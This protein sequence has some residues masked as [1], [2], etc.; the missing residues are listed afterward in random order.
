MIFIEV[1][2]HKHE[3]R[4][5]LLPVYPQRRNAYGQGVIV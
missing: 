1:Y 2:I 5:A 3:L 4:A